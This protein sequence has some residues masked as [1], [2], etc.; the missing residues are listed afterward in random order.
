[1]KLLQAIKQFAVNDPGRIAFLNSGTTLTYGELWDRSDQLAAYF[2]KQTRRPQ[3]PI[4]VYGHMGPEM[5]VSFLGSVKSGHPY[6]PVDV[7]IPVV[8]INKI[9]ESAK[10]EFFIATEEMEDDGFLKYPIEILQSTA[11]EEILLG[12]V[13]QPPAEAWV[14][15]DENFYIIYTSGS[16][17][18]PKGVQ[19]SMNNLQSFVDW[20]LKDFSINGQQNFL[21]QAPFSFD[22]SVMDLYPALCSGGTLFSI[23]KDMIANPK[24]LFAELEASDVNVWTSTP[25]FAQM[26]L[27]EPNFK[28]ELL[29]NLETFLFCGEILP[30][31]LAKQLM[32]RFPRARIFNLYGPTE[33][34]VAVT[35]LEVTK[36]VLDSHSVLP[37]G[38]CK[39][40]TELLVINENG[41]PAVDGEKGELVII[42]PS[43]SKGYLGEPLLTE[44]SFSINN[45]QRSYRTGDAGYR[46]DG[47]F[48]YSG[49]LD[50]QV[51]VHGY[52][53]EMEE[54]EYNI[55]I[56]PYV[57]TCVVEPVYCDGKID[58]LNAYVVPNNHS[59][60]KE[61]QLTSAI[62][63]ELSQQLPAYMIPRKFTY[64]DRLPMTANG[65]VNRK[66]LA[67]G[68]LI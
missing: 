50:F 57:K 34:T 55:T 47:V 52:R 4:L 31:K 26:C 62:R 66:K 51:K 67:A 65:K 40:D 54:I 10:P 38:Y 32:D 25:S 23:T 29:P 59:F 24:T 35:K 37:I 27:M 48:Y 33:A 53:M 56:S 7:S 60:E 18:N 41:K 14:K 19:I 21:N 46:K 43:V 3:S 13:Q 1:M 17:G 5:I 39:D 63:K 16:T 20:I 11:L 8:R 45:G 44:K 36:E 49:R 22:L 58:F 42:G 6:I 68:V 2:L 12:S 9:I 30:V 61:Y 64:L 28:L 15:G